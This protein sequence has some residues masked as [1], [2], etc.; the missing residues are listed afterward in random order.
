MD[1]PLNKE[2]IAS[3]KIINKTVT[4]CFSKLNILSKELNFNNEI[5]LKKYDIKNIYNN[6]FCVYDGTRNKQPILPEKL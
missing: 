2:E 1:V 4:D 5:N 3:N 6:N